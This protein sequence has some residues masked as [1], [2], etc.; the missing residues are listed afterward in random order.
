MLG[1]LVLN[2]FIWAVICHIAAWSLSVE[3]SNSVIV[4]CVFMEFV[5]LTIEKFNGSR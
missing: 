4:L 2:G 1:R 3:L 5:S